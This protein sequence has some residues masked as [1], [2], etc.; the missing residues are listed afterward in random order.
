MNFIKNVC[1]PTITVLMFITISGCE[2][3]DN[4]VDTDDTIT[5]DPT[6]LRVT[7]IYPNDCV[8]SAAYCDGFH[9]GV[10]TAESELGI[11]LT[12]VNG[13]ENDPVATE[14][15]MRDAAQN[16]DLVITAGYQMGD[17]LKLVALDFPDVKFSIFDVVSR[18][19]KRCC[20]E[21]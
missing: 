21:L 18:Y 13:N 16:S 14:M 2:Y 15:L 3:V 4:V 19:A 1:L 9:I 11:I 5:K 20:S 17:I 7:M 8:G 12:E 10:R 6:Q